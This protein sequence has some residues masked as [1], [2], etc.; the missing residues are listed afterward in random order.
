MKIQ[1]VNQPF[2]GRPIEKAVISSGIMIFFFWVGTV[3]D[4]NTFAIENSTF[5]LSNITYDSINPEI[6][7]SGDDIHSSWISNVDSNNSDIMFT[8]ISNVSG[9]PASISNI[10]NTP[11]ISNIIKLKASKNNVYIT[12]EDKQS[13]QWQLLF[14]KSQDGGETFSNLRNLSDTTGNVHLHDLST[15]RGNVFVVWAANENISS[16]NKDIFFRRSVNFGNSFDETINLSNNTDDS[17]DPHMITN[18]NGTFIYIVW[19]ECDIKH[20]DPICSIVFTKSLN[21]GE[22]FSGPIKVSNGMMYS[23]DGSSVS[24]VLNQTVVNSNLNE[25]SSNTSS[26]STI[27]EG[28]NSINPSIFAT[29]DGRQIYVIWEQIISAKGNSEIFLTSSKDYGSSFNQIFNVSNTPG[30]SRLAHGQLLG[31]DVYVAWSDTINHSRTFDIML[32]K[33]DAH[34]ITNYVRNLSNNSGNSISPNLLATDGKLFVTWSDYTK[35]PSILLWSGDTL[36]SFG[37]EEKLNS[38]QEEDYINPL[39][40]KAKNKLWIVWTQYSIDRHEIVLFSKKIQ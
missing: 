36:R 30:I 16:T 24:Y 37:I 39:I 4:S 25:P 9:L 19:T 1:R 23:D 7:V 15:S 6:S 20:D 26:N 21:Q 38:Q 31:E 17:L 40:F 35:N 8:K 5:I 27:K 12:W 2:I 14:R 33:I 10:S 11:G 29:P 34:G 3:F 18:E 32:R 13:G 28:I 22:S